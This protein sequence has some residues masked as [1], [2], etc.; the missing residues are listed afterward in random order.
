MRLLW[1]INE[2]GIKCLDQCLTRVKFSINVKHL[3]IIEVITGRFIL[4]V[5]LLTIPL[6]SFTKLCDR[7]LSWLTSILTDFQNP[8][9]E[10]TEE[11]EEGGRLG[12]GYGG[13]AEW[14]GRPEEARWRGNEKMGG[15]TRR[16]GVESGRG[17]SSGLQTPNPQL[18]HSAS[19]DP[20]L[21]DPGH[22]HHLPSPLLGTAVILWFPLPNHLFRKPRH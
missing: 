17:S 5:I 3:I 14:A 7:C 12:Y 6:W 19:L 22:H 13:E 8:G 15:L 1:R 21:P 11:S 4:Q 10:V 20:G 9:S 18:S 16:R 2:T